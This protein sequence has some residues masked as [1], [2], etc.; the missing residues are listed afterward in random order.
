MTVV[1]ETPRP[2]PRSRRLRWTG[3][4]FRRLAEGGFLP[5]GRRFE[6]LAGEIVERMP[7]N[8]AH[9]AI[10]TLLARLLREALPPG[11]HLRQE[12]PIRLDTGTEPQPDLA[13]VRGAEMDF[14]RA[15]PTAADVLLVVEVADTSLAADRGLKLRLY[16]A[17]GIPEYWVLDLR[18]EA[19]EV[20]R[21]PLGSRYPR[22]EVLA[23][24]HRVAVPG[25]AGA[26][27]RVGDLLGRGEAPAP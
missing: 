20:Y 13:V 2:A 11:L 17:A 6:L 22:R 16:A 10:V 24:H 18:G 19:L 27:L 21:E 7:P 3:E 8:P 1:T 25:V 4:Q 26:E 12:N 5:E 15:Y 14:A 23:A 9:A